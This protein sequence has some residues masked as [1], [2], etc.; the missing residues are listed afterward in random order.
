MDEHEK[1]ASR[2]AVERARRSLEDAFA[3]NEQSI[4][5][6]ADLV[7]RSIMA[8]RQSVDQLK[9]ARPDGLSHE[10]KGVL[11]SFEVALGQALH[12]ATYLSHQASDFALARR[13]VAAEK[14]ISAKVAEVIP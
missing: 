13:L 7:E 14:Q 12:L 6:S 8:A 11:L 1:S 3:S 9:R 5:T 4:L 10:E 2:V